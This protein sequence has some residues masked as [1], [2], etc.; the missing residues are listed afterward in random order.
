MLNIPTI[1]KNLLI[2]NV[3]VFLLAQVLPEMNNVLALH[4]FQASHF[5]LHQMVTYMFMH[6]GFTHLFFNMFALWMF[7]MVM[8]QTWGSQRFLL[9]YLVCGVGAGVCQEIAQFVSI[10]LDLA[11]QG[12][13]LEQFLRI[14]EIAPHIPEQLNG[15]TTVGASGSIFGILLA[16]GMTYPENKMF[17]F[18]IPFPIKAKWFVCGYAAIELFSALGNPGDHVAHIAHLGGMLFGFFLIRYWRHV[19]QARKNQ[20]SGWDSYKGTAYDRGE[21][22]TILSKI[23]SIFRVD[24]GDVDETKL[25]NGGNFHSTSTHQQDWD[26][27]ARRKAEDE[28]IDRILDKIRRCGYDGLTKEEKQKLFDASKK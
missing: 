14:G 25:N 10:Y 2:I 9:Y 3:L 23:K 21:G 13:T 6:G 28:E 5:R 19:A 17:V 27:N 15:L 4:Y 20:F 16:F 8:E 11:S 26:Y 1:T 12:V 7:G 22:S 18:P 24:R